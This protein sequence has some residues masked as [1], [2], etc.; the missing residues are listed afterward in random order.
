M[1]HWKSTSLEFRLPVWSAGGGI[2]SPIGASGRLGAYGLAGDMCLGFRDIRI[3]DVSVRTGIRELYR[4][5]R[6]G[7]GENGHDLDFSHLC[8][9]SAHDCVLF[10][11]ETK[12]S[13]NGVGSLLL[14]NLWI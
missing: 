8:V 11:G 6:R 1:S 3:R 13:A 7:R 4:G 10:F 2:C 9:G 5:H 12:E 14:C